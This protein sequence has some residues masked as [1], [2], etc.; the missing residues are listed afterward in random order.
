[1]NTYFRVLKYIKP[2]KLI[3]VFALLSSL[4][5]VVMNST[6]VWLMG[7]MVS[8]IM[9][10]NS[11]GELEKLGELNPAASLNEKLNYWTESLVGSGTPVD[12]LKMLCILLLILYIAKNIFFYLNNLSLAFIQNRM[13]KDIRDELFSHINFLSMSFFDRTRSAEMSSILLGDVSAMRN[14][15]TQSVQSLFREPINILVFLSLLLIISPKMTMLA[16]VTIPLSTLLIVKIGQSIRRKAKRSSQQ[17]AGVMNILQETISG[18]RIVQAFSMERFEIKRFALEN[19]QYFKL[20]FRQARLSN[21]TTPINDIIGVCIGVILLWYG[22]TAVLSGQGLTPEDFMRFIILLFAMMQPVKKL[23]NVNAQ[24]QAGLASADRVF[25]ILDTPI[26]VKDIDNPLEIDVFEKCIEFKNVT[27]QYESNEYPSLNKINATIKKGS[28]TA[29]VGMSGA[30]KST[31]VDLIPRFYEPADGVISF[32]G[33]DI[34]E[35]SLNS[36]RSLMGIV[37]QET[38]LFNDTVANNIAYGKTEIP[39]DKI[40]EAAIAANADEFIENLPSGYETVIGEKGTRLSGGQ[41]Q[42]LSIA[43]AILKN[44][45]IIILDEATSALDSEAEKKVQKAIHKLMLDRT[46]IVIAHRLSTVV[47]ADEILVFDNGKIIE[48]GAHR[49]LISENSRYK[50]LYES[51]FENPRLES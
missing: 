39:I 45:P 43:R 4:L 26:T 17:I 36:L 48:S 2:Y 9:L 32:D 46:V 33:T 21:L 10:P 8:K 28:M 51:Q 5:F 1:M 16:L 18:I 47:N 15:F 44:P 13:I 19:L 37:T 23:A 24:I 40:K 49:S 31:F 7:S 41:R 34:R 42:R 38:I 50:L 22:G 25:G 3:L 12:Q 14:A 30:G 35:I 29:L 11:A 6:A 27:F 20:I